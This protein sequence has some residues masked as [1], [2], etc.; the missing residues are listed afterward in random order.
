MGRTGY[1]VTAVLALLAFILGFAAVTT[2]LDL[3]QPINA[4]DL[5]VVQFAVRPGD[6]TSDIATHLQ[7][8]GL[9]RS[10]IVFRMAAGAHHLAAQVRPGT[11]ALSPY[12]TIDAIIH[13]LNTADPGALP[14]EVP[15]G[16]V[17]LDVP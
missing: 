11:Y 10:A 4:D 14:V 1:T 12:M 7:D 2:V 5:S 6:A 15:L 3:S 9:I 13:Q 16:K 17:L 8:A